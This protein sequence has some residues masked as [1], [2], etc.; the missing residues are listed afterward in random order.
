MKICRFLNR[1][2]LGPE[3]IDGPACLQQ[4]LK[5]MELGLA[6][7]G[8][9]PMI[10]SYLPLNIIPEAGEPCCVLDAGGT[11]LRFARA[12]FDDNRNCSFRNLSKTFM[13]GTR[14][15]LSFDQYNATLADY[16]RRSGCTQRIGF[17]FS[18]NVTQN[19]DLDGILDFWC[20]EVRVSDA[21]GKP[22]GESLRQAIGDSC[23]RVVVLNDSVAALL[24]A[25]NQE[26][27]V[28]LG[29]ILGTGINICYEEACRNIPK[30]PADLTDGSMIISTEIGE[31]D[32][33]PKSTF[34]REVM[35]ASDEPAMAHGEKQCA[36][37]Y[38]G[39]LIS[40]AW[41]AAVRPNRA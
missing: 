2:G 23:K 41:Q 11:N 10:P 24:G 38:L 29:L 1:H 4:L 33:F 26:P 40:R 30:L 22:V 15:E 14:G 19:R 21:P 27:H 5:E 13:P 9:I 34:D 16:V 25:H 31:F 3:A 35:E 7:K 28:T 37:G 39:S 20:K 36:G 12:E 6:G 17:C 8:R 32:G 18:Y